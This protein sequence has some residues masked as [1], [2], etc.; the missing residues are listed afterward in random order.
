MMIRITDKT[1][2]LVSKLL[3]E[4]NI[5]SKVKDSSICIRESE[6]IKNTLLNIDFSKEEVSI[7]SLGEEMQEEL[8]YVR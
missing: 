6:Y 8:F 3:A 4:L 5:D 2:P 1:I 7:S